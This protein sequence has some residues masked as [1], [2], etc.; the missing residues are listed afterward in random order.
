[1]TFP[2]DPNVLRFLSLVSKIEYQDGVGVA[3]SYILHGSSTRNANPLGPKHDPGLQRNLLAYLDVNPS[4]GSID[5]SPRYASNLSAFIK[6][7]EADRF[8]WR[9]APVEVC[10]LKRVMLHNQAGLRPRGHKRHD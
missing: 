7:G 4:A 1:M 3:A 8:V 2:V 5:A 6:P 10:E 9:N